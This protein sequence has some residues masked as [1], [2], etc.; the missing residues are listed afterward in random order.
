MGA[1]VEALKDTWTV[2][3]SQPVVAAAAIVTGLLAPVLSFGFGLIPLLGPI[4][5]ALLVQ[6]VLVGGLLHMS[7]RAMDGTVGVDTWTEGV[8]ENYTSLAGAFG[9]LFL[10][11]IVFAVVAV[12]VLMVFGV[13]G[14]FAGGGDP[15]SVTASSMASIALGLLLVLLLAVVLGIAIQFVDAA[16]VVGGHAAAESVGASVRTV[17]DSPVSVLGYSVLRGVFVGMA[18]LGPMLFV[19]GSVVG[20]AGGASGADG[21]LLAEMGLWLV[22]FAVASTVVGYLGTTVYHALYYRR[23]GLVAV[24]HETVADAPTADRVARTGP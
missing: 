20:L 4:A 12:I 1:T 15:A 7:D 11:G 13:A 21:G 10:V 6:P 16:V 9:I 19:A 18:F 24:D 8:R 14:V 17:R 23:V 2:V 5:F 3:T 22:L